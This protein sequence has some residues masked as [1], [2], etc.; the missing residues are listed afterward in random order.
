MPTNIQSYIM[1]LYVC[2]AFAF[3]AVVGGK[4]GINMT[5]KAYGTTHQGLFR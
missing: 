2:L 4:M 3:G 5:R 1:T